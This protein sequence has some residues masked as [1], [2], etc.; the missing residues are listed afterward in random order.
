MQPRAVVLEDW[1]APDTGGSALVLRTGSR[2][3]VVY[4]T[5]AAASAVVTFARASIVKVGSPNDEALGGHPL[6]S[7]GLRHY[8]VHKVEHS[9]WLQSPEQ[10]NS[11]HPQH[12]RTRFLKDKVHYL[13]ALK[14]ETVECIVVE[15]DGTKPEIEVFAS[16][17]E[18]HSRV[19]NG[20]DA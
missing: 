20:I 8:S 5:G 10:Q 1:P 11:V 13:F 2:L 19:K 4:G 7:A 15:P 6:F 3:I 9:P 17:Q 12:D 14:E 16:R 18:A